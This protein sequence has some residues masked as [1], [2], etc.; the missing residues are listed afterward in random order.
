MKLGEYY[1]NS[2]SNL[3]N[4]DEEV[5]PLV[6]EIQTIKEAIDKLNEQMK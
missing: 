4:L 5:K 3:E 1:Y 2:L 6:G